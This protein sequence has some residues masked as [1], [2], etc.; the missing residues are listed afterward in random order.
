MVRALEDR[1]GR[2]LTEARMAMIRGSMRTIMGE[3]QARMAAIDHIMGERWEDTEATGGRIR[4]IDDVRGSTGGRALEDPPRLLRLRG[5]HMETGE[6]DS[7]VQNQDYR[8]ENG[9][10][11]RNPRGGASEDV[12]SE[13]GSTS[14]GEPG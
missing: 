12:Q 13:H 2:E 11:I 5:A 14:E 10:G 1:D 3:Q 8:G 9:A 4:T 7:S 6:S